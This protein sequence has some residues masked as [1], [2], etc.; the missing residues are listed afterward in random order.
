MITLLSWSFSSWFY[1]LISP[2]LLHPVQ[3]ILNMSIRSSEL[4]LLSSTIGLFIFCHYCVLSSVSNRFDKRII[5]AKT[6]IKSV[7]HLHRYDVSQFC[8]WW[9]ELWLSYHNGVLDICLR[10]QY[11]YRSKI[12]IDPN[13][14]Y[15]RSAIRLTAMSMKGNLTKVY[16]FWKNIINNSCVMI[17]W[18]SC[19]L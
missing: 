13:M 8:S 5:N 6:S 15:K 19:F 17:T 11:W 2:K 14:Q 1:S 9:T 3:R 4:I 7:R 10:K 16:R 18:Y 12:T